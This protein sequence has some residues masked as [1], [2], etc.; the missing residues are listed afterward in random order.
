MRWKWLLYGFCLSACLLAAGCQP[1]PQDLARKQ[2]QAGLAERQAR[3]SES[4]K[5]YDEGMAHYRSGQLA[6]AEGAMTQAIQADDG[7][8]VAWTARGIV[9]AES[10]QPLQ[11]LQSFERA[12]RLAPLRY[13]PRF[14]MGS[15]FESLGRYEQAVC[16]YQQALELA[17]GELQTMENLARCYIHLNTKFDQAGELIRR[18]LIQEMRPEWRMWLEDQAAMLAR[19]GIEREVAD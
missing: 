12:S 16:F 17:P 4:A 8:A 9:L 13:E 7:N 6:K 14:N 19:K 10:D 18:A 11:A 15:A 5:H 2:F 3:R 1:S